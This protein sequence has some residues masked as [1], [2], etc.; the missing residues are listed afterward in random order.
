MHWKHVIAFKIRCCFA[1]RLNII[2]SDMCVILWFWFFYWEKKHLLNLIN[3]LAKYCIKDVP[4]VWMTPHV[5]SIIGSCC[6]A[7]NLYINV[8]QK[9]AY[10]L[11]F[12]FWK[13]M[14]KYQLKNFCKKYCIQITQFLWIGSAYQFRFD[15]WIKDTVLTKETRVSVTLTAFHFN[16]FYCACSL[17]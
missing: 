4:M 17:S 1:D 12:E 16:Y 8:Y 3:F 15:K 14:K 13:L 6:F 9:C 7:D 2:I 10:Y 11:D 5:T